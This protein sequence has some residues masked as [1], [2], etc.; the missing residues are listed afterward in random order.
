[1]RQP[2]PHQLSVII[3]FRREYDS[4]WLD[5][6]YALRFRAEKLPVN[7]L[8]RPAA[9]DA[10]ATLSSAAGF[11]LEQALV[12][13][14][15]ATVATDQGVSPVD[16][17]IGLLTLSNRVQ[18]TGRTDVTAAEYQLAGG[19]EGLLLAYVQ[20]RL[21][22]V[23]ESIR[24]GLLRGLIFTLVDPST[25]QRKAEGA[26][27]EEI[28]SKAELPVAQLEH[29]L[30]RLAHPRIRLLEKIA[31]ADE[32]RYR[33]QH[34]RLI[35]VLRRL[36]GA[37]LAQL[38]Q[39]RLLFQDR[40]GHWKQTGSSQYLLRGEDLRRTQQFRDAL[41][42]G[43][44]AAQR[45]EYFRASI[46]RRSFLR[47]ASLGAI[48]A[49]ISGG[50]WLLKLEDDRLQE[51]RLASWGLPSWLF[52]AQHQI[53]G[54]RIPGFHLNDLSWL[55]GNRLTE[56]W[57]SCQN[58]HSLAGLEKAKKLRVLV[59]E[60]VFVF[61]KDLIGPKDL[62]SITLSG[63]RFPSSIELERLKSIAP[64]TISRRVLSGPSSDPNIE[65]LKRANS[66]NLDLTAEAVF[67]FQEGKLGDL[68]TRLRDLPAVTLTLEAEQLDRYQ[69]E[70]GELEGHTSL[71]LQPGFGKPVPFAKI[72]DE[73][74]GLKRLRSVALFLD[75]AKIP[76]V[77]EVEDQE[78]HYSLTLNFSIKNPLDLNGVENFKTVDTFG[79]DFSSTD[80]K[81]PADFDL[82]LE[83]IDRIPP[84]IPVELRIHPRLVVSASKLRTK[85]RV[86]LWV[87]VYGASLPAVPQGFKFIGLEF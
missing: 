25:S 61:P 75:A 82:S 77:R 54:L 6:E 37:V 40:F 47:A 19:A 65:E 8:S 29:W 4:E 51:T 48:G 14:F 34:E 56:L 44:D 64:V 24:A 53:D 70:I 31:G 84:A 27:L 16:L 41:L 86:S 35:P 67:G 63:L 18:Q 1:V 81:N 85:A 83:R 58:L 73:V 32:L 74:A 43:A 79:F 60:S 36:T 80:I 23:P 59:L 39:T 45:I 28:A 71:V 10:M 69:K 52:Q 30:D 49:A 78:R 21:Q 7:L 15:I 17:A 13:N 3:G 2:P 62:V 72:K 68:L 11:T 20:D 5:F 38:D 26:G 87:K 9:E 50:S 12:T 42:P 33:L 55:R 76:Q 46:R 22:E 57:L 66:V